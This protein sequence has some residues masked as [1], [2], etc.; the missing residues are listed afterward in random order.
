MAKIGFTFFISIQTILAAVFLLRAPFMMS[1]SPARPNKPWADQPCPLI[2]TPLV[3][4]QKVSY[5]LAMQCKMFMPTGDAADRH[6]Y[7]RRD[8]YGTHS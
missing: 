8:P 5:I 1:A 2:T 6:F 3:A 7:H 4:T